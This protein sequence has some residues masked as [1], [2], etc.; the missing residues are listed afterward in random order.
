MQMPPLRYWERA[1]A[2]QTMVSTASSANRIL[3]PA[4]QPEARWKEG[5]ANAFWASSSSAHKMT[6]AAVPGIPAAGLRRRV[7]LTNI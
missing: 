7:W 1:A 5:I 6:V 2:P 4:L 3:M